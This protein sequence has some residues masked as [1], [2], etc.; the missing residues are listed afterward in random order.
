MNTPLARSLDKVAICAAR[1]SCLATPCLALLAV[2]V[3]C[4]DDSSSTGL[5]EGDEDGGS[6]V[7]ASSPSGSGL[8]EGGEEEGGSDSASDPSGDPSGDPGGT[9]GADDVGE[10]GG[11]EGSGG[12]E[13][14]EPEPGQLTAGEWRDLDHWDFWQALQQNAMWQPV[15]AAWGFGTQER[16][17]VVVESDGEHVVD[18]EVTLLAGQ[19][20][21]WSARTDA[22]GEAELF[23]GMF[24]AAPEGARSLEVTVA[25]KK[26]VVE[27]VE[28][29][30][31]TPIVVAV[32]GA[33]PPAQVLDLMFVIDTTG[34]MGDELATCR[35]SSAT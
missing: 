27:A 9:G 16:F 10:E 29:G 12:G 11:E 13:P 18:A 17:A 8:Y 4:G 2:A 7:S 20:P 35:R 23:A 28:A 5:Y 15:L 22:H 31:A 26:T 32:D 14:V 24:A 3:G 21:V 6:G 30:G 1:L 25:G 34:S 33:E 19:V